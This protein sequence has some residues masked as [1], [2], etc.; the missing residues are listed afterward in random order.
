MQFLCIELKLQEPF[1]ICVKIATAFLVK[2]NNVRQ[3]NYQRVLK[4]IHYWSSQE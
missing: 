2:L 3:L 4:V 1:E